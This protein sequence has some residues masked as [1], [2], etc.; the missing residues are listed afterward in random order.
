LFEDGDGFVDCE[1]FDTKSAAQKEFK[2]I[3][4]KA[5]KEIEEANA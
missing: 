5:E 2:K 3:A 1:F 4:T